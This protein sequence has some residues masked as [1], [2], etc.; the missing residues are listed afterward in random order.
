MYCRCNGYKYPAKIQKAI[1]DL[2]KKD[3]AEPLTTIIADGLD[4]SVDG[5]GWNA[6]HQRAA[7][8]ANAA[9]ELALALKGIT[10]WVKHNA[11]GCPWL[12]DAQAALR[13]AGIEA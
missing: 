7:N 6:E 1:A 3:A 12:T 9:P 8:M 2:K 10:A 13:K 11:H 4:A 5:R